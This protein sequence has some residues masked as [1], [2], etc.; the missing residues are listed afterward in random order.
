MGSADSVEAG[1][2]PGGRHDE[3]GIG[4]EPGDLVP[5]HRDVEPDAE[6][7]SMADVWRDEEPIR[8]AGDERI[9]D[10]VGRRAPETEPI[11]VVMVGIRYEDAL[12]I[13]EPGRLAVAQALGRA[14]QGEAK[15]A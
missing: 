13:D 15:A 3:P 14:R 9:L 5:V 12:V 1:P 8:S 2:K 4:D 10:A 11:V 6:P 7:A